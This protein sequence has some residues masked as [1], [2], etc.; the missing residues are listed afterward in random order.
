[1]N[2]VVKQDLTEVKKSLGR[3]LLNAKHDKRFL[4]RFYEIF[5]DSHPAI[6]D[7][8]SDTNFEKQLMA[9]KN[10]L[11]MAILYAEGDS[12]AEDVLKHI[13]VTHN[14][15]HMAINPKL[16]PHWSGSLLKAIEEFDERLDENTKELWTYVLRTSIDYITEGY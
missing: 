15:K 9:L 12:L 11:N 6:K 4:E 8:F 5:L 10:G 7:A 14:Q 16:Y 2:E 3:C 13:Q 1:M